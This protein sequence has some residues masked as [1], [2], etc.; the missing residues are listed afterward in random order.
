MA[1]PNPYG[2]DHQ[3][4]RARLIAAHLDGTPCD[5]CWRPMY[6][7]PKR[8]HDGR[9]LHA[10]HPHDRPA[11]V[12]PTSRATHLE[13]A[14]CNQAGLLLPRPQPVRTREW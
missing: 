8:N 11:G 13:H 6:A 4:T 3:Q 1:K 10:A 7:D 12:D 2:W 9:A 14:K 5:R